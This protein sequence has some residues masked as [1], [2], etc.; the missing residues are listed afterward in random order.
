MTGTAS[1]SARELRKIYKL[2]VVPI[3]T[4]RPAIRE[5]LP[6][7]GL[8]HERG[9]VG[10]RSSRKSREMHAAGRPV[11]IGTRSIDKSELLSQL[12]KRRGHRAPGAQRQSRRRGGRDRRRGRPARQGHRRHEHGRPRHR[13]Q[14]R[15][16]R[17]RARRPARDLHRAA[18][19]RPASTAS[20]SAAAAA[21]ATPARTGSTWRSTTTSCSPASVPKKAKKLKAQRRR[22]RRPL[23]PS[24]QP[25]PQGPAAHR[26][27][28]L[29][30][31]QAADV[32]RKGTQR[33]CSPNGPG[34]LSRHGGGVL[35]PPSPV[36]RRRSGASLTL[37]PLHT[38]PKRSEGPAISRTPNP[39]GRRGTLHPTR[40]ASAYFFLETALGFPSFLS[41][42][43]CHRF[44][45]RVSAQAL[46][47]LDAPPRLVEQGLQLRRTREEQLLQV[48]VIHGSHQHGNRLPV[49]RNDHRSFGRHCFIGAETRLDV[50]QRPQ[51]S[52]QVAPNGA[53]CRKG[54]RL[55][56][57]LSGAL[58]QRLSIGAQ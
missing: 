27:P 7:A 58:A 32:P 46:A 23:R 45:E 52:Y 50:G 31:P 22:L 16:R 51:F 5:R 20:S 55:R 48:V 13:H 53:G 14:A 1:T 36:P 8:R 12:L 17:R 41:A 37:H 3:P 19:R 9:Q 11:L 40:L 43:C 42:A 6:D 34:S 47:G 29:P 18:R 38:S 4:N 35:G 49:T 56:V 15:R 54:L 44:P 10:R 26:A 39:G 28:P 2:R 21:R 57:A 24:G 25:V 30:R 33:R